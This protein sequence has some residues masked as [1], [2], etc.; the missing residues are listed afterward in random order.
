MYIDDKM[1]KFPREKFDNIFSRN[2][3]KNSNVPQ[4]GADVMIAIFDHFL[5]KDCRFSQKPMSRLH[6]LALS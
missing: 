6:N 3:F 1:K 2:A 5:R 4:T